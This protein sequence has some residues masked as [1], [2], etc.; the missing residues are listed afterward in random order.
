[1]NNSLANHSSKGK[2]AAHASLPIQSNNRKRTTAHGFYRAANQ[3]I[4]ISCYR[5]RR[6]LS[7]RK[8]NIAPIERI[9]KVC[10]AHDSAVGARAQ[11]RY[12]G[13]MPWLESSDPTPLTHVTAEGLWVQIIRSPGPITANRAALFLDRDG[14]IIKDVGFLSQPEKLR[15]IEGAAQTI[16]TANTAGISV[17]IVTNQSGIG[18][19]LFGWPA[20]AAVQDHM[21]KGLKQNG[22]TISA[23]LACPHH[24]EAQ[25]PYDHPDHP[26]RKPN[27]GMIRLAAQILS[28]DLKRSWLIGDRA[29]DITAARRAGLAGGMLVATGPAPDQDHVRELVNTVS[30]GPFQ[31]LQAESIGEAP[32]RMPLFGSNRITDRP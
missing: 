18:R 30:E 9:G 10:I 13:A 26:S 27:P 16:R 21:L 28:V 17:V 12:R 11:R 31:F 29:S 8:C 23:V 32:S 4:W 7:S 3:E 22:A 19:G 5:D 20:F 6:S 14:T 2:T 1:M 24:P 15:F 25:P